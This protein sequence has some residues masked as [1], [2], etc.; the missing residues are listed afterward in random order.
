[1]LGNTVVT[2]TIGE[3][4]V[5]YSCLVNDKFCLPAL[6]GLNVTKKLKTIVNFDD[7]SITFKQ[8]KKEKFS[9]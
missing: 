9:T 4:E 3:I 5:T 1:V 8:G 7:N 6:R 2:I